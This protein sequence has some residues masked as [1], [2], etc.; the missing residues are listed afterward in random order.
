MSLHNKKG[1][2]YLS[3]KNILLGQIE[4]ELDILDRHVNLLTI[5][6]EKQPIGIIRLSELTKAPHH[7]VRYS[8]RILE[9]EGLIEPSPT[10]AVATQKGKTFIGELIEVLRRINQRMTKLEKSLKPR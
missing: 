8:L 3:K 4:S 2:N 7:K 10:G 6:I 1:G 9:K 5:I